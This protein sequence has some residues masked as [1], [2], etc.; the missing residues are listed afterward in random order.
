MRHPCG[1]KKETDEFLKETAVLFEVS[2]R[3]KKAE[4]LLN[5][6]Y[7]KEL[8]RTYD[9]V[10]RGTGFISGEAGKKGFTE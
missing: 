7:C 1:I 3:M 6:K 9:D 10:H 5:E 8:F 4:K 2:Q